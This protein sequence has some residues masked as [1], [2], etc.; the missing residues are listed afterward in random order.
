MK[1]SEEKKEI[2]KAYNLLQKQMR[3]ASKDSVNPH[4][5]SK[6]SSYESTWEALR[7]PL[8]DNG[9]S[10]E[11]DVTTGEKSVSVLTFVLHVSGEWMEFGPLTM[12]VNKLDCQG[13]ASAI[14]Y[15]K[16]YALQAAFGIVSGEDDDG[17]SAASNGKPQTTVEPKL[18]PA[19]LID[20]KD[21]LKS[22]PVGYEPWLCN[23]VIKDANT[24][25]CI[26]NAP[27]SSFEYCKKTILS[28]IE[29]QKK[30][31]TP[32]ENENE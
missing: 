6:Y 1:I 25:K 28:Y 4:F 13:F 32:K 20:L 3:P 30:K 24:A 10:C 23:L 16:R 5:R 18:G 12:P 29:D 15:A 21:L 22:C 7:D 14:S 17:N 11:Q 9:L 26:E 19:Q 8:T 27:F 31:N 2:A